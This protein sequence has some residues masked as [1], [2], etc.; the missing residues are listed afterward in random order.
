MVSPSRIFVTRA[1]KDY[2]GEG[3]TA[4]GVVTWVGGGC[5]GDRGRPA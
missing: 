1:V 2:V 3:E 4:G 5:T